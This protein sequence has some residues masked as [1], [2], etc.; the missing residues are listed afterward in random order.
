MAWLKKQDPPIVADAL[1]LCEA[2]FSA[3][4]R[5]VSEGEVARIEQLHALHVKQAREKFE[6]EKSVLAEEVRIAKESAD[7]LAHE[8]ERR[9]S[10]SQ[11]VLRGKLRQ[12]QRSVGA[13]EGHRDRGGRPHAARRTGRGWHAGD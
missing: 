11:E 5:D 13:T 10:D 9:Y 7:S 1:S 8:N 2:A 6:R 3:V 12:A 4:R